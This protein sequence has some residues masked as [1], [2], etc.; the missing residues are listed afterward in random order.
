MPTRCTVDPGHWLAYR[1][2][3]NKCTA[4]IRKAKSRHYVNFIP[5][6][7]SNPAKFWRAVNSVK[8]KSS[9]SFPTINTP[10]G[11]SLSDQVEICAAF[12]QHFAS[13]G[14]LFDHT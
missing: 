8:Y 7:Y 10:D 11:Y 6:V 1:Q 13:A 2:L 12:N 9:P 14:H 5:K 3:R 4:G